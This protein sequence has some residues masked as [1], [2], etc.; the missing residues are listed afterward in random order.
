MIKFISI[1]ILT[2][3]ILTFSSFAEETKIR[4]G[5]TLPL[6]GDLATY[7][8][9]IK[10]GI[11][12][13]KSDLKSEGIDINLYFEDIPVSGNEVLAGLKKLISLDQVHGIAGNF[14]N[15]AMASMSSIIDK[16]QIPTFHTA[17]A[18][19]PLILDGSNYI[20]TTNIAIKDE[21][22]E[23]ALRMFNDYNIKKLAVIYVESNFGEA[24][25]D[26]FKSKFIEIGGSIV[27][28]QSLALSDTEF[29]M[30]ITKTLSKNPE[31]IYFGCFGRFLGHAMK[32]ARSLGSRIPF[33]S[34][35]ESEDSSV[36]ESG[37]VAAEGLKYLV[38]TA[39]SGTDKQIKFRERYFK[40][41][42]LEPGTFGSNAY[43]STILLARSLHICQLDS[44]CTIEKIYKTRDFSGVSGEFSI[45]SNG[46]ST[47]K[48]FMRTVKNGKFVD[49]N[50]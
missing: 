25:R 36:L 50:L 5:A 4:I 20:I 6:T 18:A 42:N 46:A 22:E 15:I 27:S 2:S 17:A 21:A 34:V 31:A 8:N 1:L 3:I 38:T 44:K 23:M 11:E 19:D 39:V 13:A 49:V 9:L 28:E 45:K 10:N 32:Q 43:D 16:N 7:G 35:Y 48:F 30:Q 47:K 29:K 40:K 26:F 24:Y 41:Y 14:S 12:L 33:F 37:G